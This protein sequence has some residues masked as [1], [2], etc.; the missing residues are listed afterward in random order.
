VSTEPPPVGSA[1]YKVALIHGAA[2]TSRIWDRVIAALSRALPE[3]LVVAPQRASS[4]SLDVEIDALLPACADAVV[5]GVSGGATLGL[6]LATRGVP[7]RSAVLHEPAVGSL[8]PGLLAPVVAAYQAGGVAGFGRALYGPSW[9]ITDAPADPAAVARDLAMFQAFEPAAA[10]PGSG[11]ILIT[12][13]ELSPPVRNEAAAALCETFGYSIATVP[14]SG[15]A[16]HRDAPAAL[17]SLVSRIA[18]T[19]SD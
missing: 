13:G 19:A 2:V 3:S 12:V 14:D 11:P 10:A 5:V 16:A 4:G 6:E 18:R 7:F 1:Q 8:L 17:A 9:S 15:H